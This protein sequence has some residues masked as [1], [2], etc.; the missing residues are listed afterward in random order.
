MP[1]FFELDLDGIGQTVA[2]LGGLPN[3]LQKGAILEA[4]TKASELFESALI[5]GAP[6]GPTGNYRRSIVSRVTVRAG[7]NVVVGLAGPSWPLG[8]HAHL[9]EYGTKE[10]RTRTGKSTGK[11]PAFPYVFQTFRANQDRALSVIHSTILAAVDS[12]GT[13]PS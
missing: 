10:R 13:E 12:Y 4:V 7:G 8:P 3:H 5:S 9:I 11:M 1:E 6:V 2:R